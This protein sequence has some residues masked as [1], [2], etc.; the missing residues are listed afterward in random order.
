MQ[1]FAASLLARE[2]TVVRYAIYDVVEVD[3][4]V[5]P[6]KSQMCGFR[7]ISSS[8]YPA[9]MKCRNINYMTFAVAE[10]KASRRGRYLLYA[11]GFGVHTMQLVKCLH[12]Y[13][14]ITWFQVNSPLMIDVKVNSV[15]HCKII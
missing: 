10:G 15:H 7:R 6:S 2:S 12:L 13:A 3:A 5:H 8:A 1:G 14:Y 4:L 9:H 11:C